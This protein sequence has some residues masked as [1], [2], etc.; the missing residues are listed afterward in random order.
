LGRAPSTHVI[1]LRIALPQPRFPELE[2]HLAEISDPF[3]ERYG[4]HLSKEEV[5]ELVAPHPSSLDAVREWLASHGIRSEACHQ[6][7]AGDWV[8][9]HVPVAQA[10]EMLGTV[11]RG[12]LMAASYFKL[13]Y[14]RVLW[15]QEFGVWKHDED[16]DVLVRTTEYSL[17]ALLD[18]HVE[19]IQPTT[20][21]HRAKR[22]RST[23]HFSPPYDV[24]PSV[25][26]HAKITIPGYAVPVDASCNAT[27]TVSCL[28]QLY[29][30]VNYVPQAMNKNGIALTG[31]MKEFANFADLRNF[32]A[33]QVPAA[34]NTSFNV[35]LI[36]GLSSLLFSLP[37]MMSF[38]L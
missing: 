29:N 14:P 11:C 24:S 25:S 12:C 7:P 32:Y 37:E 35:I 38:A 4:E 33:D 18:Q 22:L 31:Y 28:K 16:G 5:E 2:W 1:Q 27:I 10:E 3:H 26:T 8:T 36:S 15:Y 20:V 19:L 6:S 30:M 9:V 21:F 17:P 23:H 13:K 34:V